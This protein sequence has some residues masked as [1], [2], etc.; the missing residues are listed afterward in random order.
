MDHRGGDHPGRSLR[1]SVFQTLNPSLSQ[2][3]RDQGVARQTLRR[4]PAGDA[5]IRAENGSAP[6]AAVR[7]PFGAPAGPPAAA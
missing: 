6:G 1:I 2:A 5:A 3:A 7:R 4:I